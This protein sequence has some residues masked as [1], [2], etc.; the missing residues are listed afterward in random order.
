MEGKQ[1][2]DVQSISG[3]DR[4]RDEAGLTG[5]VRRAQV[6]DSVAHTER[7]GRDWIRSRQSRSA[8]M[9]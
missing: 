2:V 9:V 7:I 6:T 4:D 3:I 8:L 5:I 1:S